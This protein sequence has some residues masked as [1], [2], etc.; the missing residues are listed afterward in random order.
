VP[1]LGAKTVD[2][3][4]AARRRRR[5]RLEDLARLRV[6]VTRITPFIVTDDHR[7]RLLDSARLRDRLIPGTVFARA[8]RPVQLSLFA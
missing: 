5:I 1:G 7:P 6:S 3:L 4:I 8:A 2:K